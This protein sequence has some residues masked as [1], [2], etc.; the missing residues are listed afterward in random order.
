MKLLFTLL[1]CLLCLEAY[2][3][4]SDNV[5]LQPNQYRSEVEEYERKI[6]GLKRF[7]K[8]RNERRDLLSKIPKAK[9]DQASVEARIA[10][11]KIEIEEIHSRLEAIETDDR[12]T[13]Y[14]AELARTQ[15]RLN[16]LREGEKPTNQSQ[17]EYDKEVANTLEFIEY[18]RDRVFVAK[19]AQEQMKNLT[20]KASVLSDNLKVLNTELSEKEKRTRKIAGRTGDRR[21]Q[22]QRSI[23]SNYGTE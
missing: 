2:A 10:G 13:R 19:R 12:L 15:S 14:E 1:L 11:T 23:D 4:T 7:S 5:T 3:Q 16:S 6:E 20:A 8:L 17:E 22:N 21:G 18:L 9:S